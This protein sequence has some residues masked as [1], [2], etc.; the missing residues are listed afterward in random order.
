MTFDLVYSN[1]VIEHVGGYERRRRF[2]ETV[3][4]LAPHHWVQT[5]ARSFPL[6][7]HWLFPGF[8]FMPV[9]LR[10]R[11]AM[12]WPYSFYGR[13]NDA[14]ET[15]G[16]VLWVELIGVPEMTHLFPGSEV[17]RER[18]ARLTKSLIATR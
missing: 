8:Q 3:E 1:S 10:T 11:V 5:P 17:L 6:E 2:A 18:F 7:P 14:A 4:R 16:E 12:K 13:S 15:L 9:A